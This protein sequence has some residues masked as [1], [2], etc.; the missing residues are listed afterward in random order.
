MSLSCPSSRTRGHRG[1]DLSGGGA[2]AAGAG[3]E[4]VGRL[5]TGQAQVVA[6]LEG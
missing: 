3:R 6:R 4:V 1:H 5:N 2:Q